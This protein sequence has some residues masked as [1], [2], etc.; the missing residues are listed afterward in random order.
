MEKSKFLLCLVVLLMLGCQNPKKEVDKT[1]ANNPYEPSPY[2]KL[3]HPDWIKNGAI[4]QINTRQFTQEGT[5]QAAEKELTRIKELGV[6]IIMLMPIHPI[7]VENRKGSLGSPYSIK[8]YYGVNPELGTMQDLKNFIKK[9]H[10]LDMYVILDWVANHTSWDNELVAK[11]PDWYIKNEEGKFMPTAW[12]DWSDVID[13]NFDSPEVRKYM[14][15]ALRYWVKEANVDGY[16]CDAAG[17][18]PLDFWNNARKELEAIKPVLMLAEW[19]GRDFHAEA[20]DMTYAWA[21]NDA[22]HKICMGKANVNA[23][24]AYYSWNEGFYPNNAV[25]MTFVSNHDKNSWEGTMWEQFGDGVEAA[26]V[27]S[28]VGEGLP[29]IYN[30]Q[31]AGETKRLAFFEK[32]TI[33]WQDHYIGKLYKDLFGLMKKNTALWHADWGP[34]MVK[35]PN[36]VESEV[37]SFVRKNEKDKVFAVFNFSANNNVVSFKET[38]FQGEYV[39]FFTN[40]NTN[41][42]DATT[43]ELKPWDYKVFIKK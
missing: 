22:V 3:K 29:L 26:I 21:W 43:L 18:V 10:E 1:E 15:D 31:E 30:G 39:D 42:T 23:L 37:L 8:D 2:V 5:L 6:N 40:E 4:Y 35:V 32:D 25:R 7:G 14:T 9:A 38:L 27:L 41:F 19:E 17:L 13:L 33:V 36:S 11:H 20:F 34:R 16:R 24:Y 12:F 28:V